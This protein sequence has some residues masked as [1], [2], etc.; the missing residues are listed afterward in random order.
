MSKLVRQLLVLAFVVG[1]VGVMSV[2]AA[3]AAPPEPDKNAVE[4]GAYAG[5][6]FL[7]PTSTGYKITTKH[8]VFCNKKVEML[9]MFNYNEP[10]SNPDFVTA[11]EVYCYDA[12]ECVNYMDT[13]V[14]ASSLDGTWVAKTSGSAGTPDDPYRYGIIEEVQGQYWC[15]T[16]PDQCQNF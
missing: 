10:T 14:L 15:S 12:I 8:S 16:S 13:Y 2:P 9:R 6:H 7:S 5:F 3:Q 1:T 11:Q 4:C